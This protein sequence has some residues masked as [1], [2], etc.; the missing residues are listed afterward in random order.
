MR[1]RRS[2]HS[3]EAYGR[4]GGRRVSNPLIIVALLLFVVGLLGTLVHVQGVVVPAPIGE[5]SLICSNLLLLV[6]AFSR[7]M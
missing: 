4:R 1:R 6:G 2:R 5:W 3:G 7:E